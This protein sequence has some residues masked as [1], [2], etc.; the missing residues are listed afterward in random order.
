[1][2]K[3]NKWAANTVAALKIRARSPWDFLYTNARLVIEFESGVEFDS[4][5]ILKWAALLIEVGL[6]LKELMETIHIV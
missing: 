1:M 5:H 4:Y 6:V 2:I 3:K